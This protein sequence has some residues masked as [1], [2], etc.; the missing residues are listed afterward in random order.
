MK[1]KKYSQ[2]S[3]T[4]FKVGAQ[5]QDDFQ[6]NV[7]EGQHHSVS[8]LPKTAPEHYSFWSLSDLWLFG[9]WQRSTQQLKQP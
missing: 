4:H 3:E 8:I 9:T 6:S 5:G 7:K 1:T 2:K